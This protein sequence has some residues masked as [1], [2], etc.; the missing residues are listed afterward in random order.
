MTIVG[1]LIAT[2]S[3]GLML[4]DRESR[5]Q[6]IR[7]LETS[8]NDQ[9]LFIDRAGNGDWYYSLFGGIIAVAANHHECIEPLQNRVEQ[10]N[11]TSQYIDHCIQKLLRHICGTA[12]QFSLKQQF[13]ILTM[14][15]SNISIQYRLF[16]M[17]LLL[18]SSQAVTSVHRFIGKFILRHLPKKDQ[19][20]SSILAA[21]LVARSYL[22][23]SMLHETELLY[24]RLSSDGG[25]RTFENTHTDTLSTGVS[26][27]ALRYAKQDL[28]IIKTQCL[29]ELVSNYCDG[30]FLS[31][32]GDQT[33]DVEY[34]FYGL[35][36]LGALNL[37]TESNI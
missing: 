30:A 3:D 37:R 9:G 27:F 19:C 24:S 16:L 26:L 29:N 22:G 7:F 31:G 14:P 10:A 36:A 8:Q 11:D 2:V 20:P 12:L 4:L 35:L 33:R 32:D 34:T 5:H 28:R 18:D 13:R 25:F 1:Q 17:A 15:Q 21:T 23:Q 6:V